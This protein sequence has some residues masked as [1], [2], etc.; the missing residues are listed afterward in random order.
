MCNFDWGIAEFFSRDLDCFRTPP[1]S[2][3]LLCSCALVVVVVVV[4]VVLF[5]LNSNCSQA[6]KGRFTTNNNIIIIILF[7]FHNGTIVFE[8][9][10]IPIRK[11]FVH[12]KLYFR[13][14]GE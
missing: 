10:T 5:T 6:L 14:N 12:H 13:Y 2:A 8:K 3:Q 9:I 1:F 11:S 4:V 7:A